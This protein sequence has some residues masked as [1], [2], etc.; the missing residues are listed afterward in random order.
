MGQGPVRTQLPAAHTACAHRPRAQY[1]PPCRAQVP[2]RLNCSECPHGVRT[3]PPSLHP[4]EP[5]ALPSGC[6]APTLGPHLLTHLVPGW[7]QALR[8]GGCHLLPA[9][10]PGEALTRHHALCH[11]R[12]RH[13]A[14]P[15]PRPVGPARAAGTRWGPHPGPVREPGRPHWGP[16]QPAGLG[17]TTGPAGPLKTSWP[18][19]TPPPPPRAR[20][21]QTG[22]RAG[23]NC[24]TAASGVSARRRR[25]GAQRLSLTP[26]EASGRIRGAWGGRRGAHT[27]HEPPTGQTQ[28]QGPVGQSFLAKGCLREEQ[29]PQQGQGAPCRQR[30]GGHW[31]P[32]GR[33]RL[34]LSP[35]LSLD[36]RR[37]SSALAV[38]EQAPGGGRSAAEGTCP[39]ACAQTPRPPA[40][41]PGRRPHLQDTPTQ[42]LDR[43]SP[44]AR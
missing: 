34:S 14:R 10:G 1:R 4:A 13:G 36:G 37:D 9:L 30:R 28:R 44:R 39:H 43:G 15:A 41:L 18:R 32:P 7:P 38:C 21:A 11:L 20:V 8:P 29:S 17:V 40:G 6:P 19:P 27:P 22:S 25:A 33:T 2:P 5:P 12:E 31:A 26:S 24:A 3:G 23:R 42:E 16:A 35:P